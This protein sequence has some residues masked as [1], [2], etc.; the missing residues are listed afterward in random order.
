MN[1]EGNKTTYRIKKIEYCPS[2][3]G[4]PC[5]VDVEKT[6]RENGQTRTKVVSCDVRVNHAY[7]NEEGRFIPKTSSVTGESWDY[8][9][10]DFS[11]PVISIVGAN[12][13]LGE[14]VGEEFRRRFQK[15]REREGW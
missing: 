6:Y 9:K 10:C 5:M 3:C 15:Q 7:D 12:N 11:T 13:G 1:G 14:F 8:S 2:R 4:Q